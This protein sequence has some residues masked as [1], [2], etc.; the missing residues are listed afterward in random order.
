MGMVRKGPRAFSFPRSMPAGFEVWEPWTEVHCK[1]GME[2]GGLLLEAGCRHGWWQTPVPWGDFLF[3]GSSARSRALGT[4]S[5]KALRP[6]PH[7]IFLDRWF[8]QAKAPLGL[9]ASFSPNFSLFH[10]TTLHCACK[11][12]PVVSE[13]IIGIMFS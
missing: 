4:L 2:Y 13:L 8:L 1:K 3:S 6:H 9:Y 11:D 12:L 7:A 5:F 10:R